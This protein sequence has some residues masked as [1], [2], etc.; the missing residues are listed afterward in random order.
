MAMFGFFNFFN[1][2]YRSHPMPHGLEGFRIA[3]RLKMDYFRY[4]IAMALSIVLGTICSFWAMLW[5]FNKYGAAA[6]V[7]GPGEWFGREAWEEVNTWIT[8][9]QLHQ[10]QPTYAILVGLFFSLG[11]AAMRM[12]LSWWP[13]H[14]VGYAVSGSW[15]MDQL[16]TCVLVAWIIKVLLLKYGGARAYRPAVPFFLGLIM[17]DF[18]VGSF[19]N[20]YG[21][22]NEVQVY[23]FWPY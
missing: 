3:E 15:S 12:N 18:V 6:Q 11:L 8:L 14:P 22:I 13:F 7:M 1:R 2:A 23:H 17:G 19:W 21:I 4:F 9:P 5:V 20:L 16:W 10:Y